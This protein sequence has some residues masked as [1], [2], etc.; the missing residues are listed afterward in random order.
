MRNTMKINNTIPWDVAPVAKTRIVLCTGLWLRMVVC[1]S[2]SWKP[3]PYVA[4]A[5]AMICD[6]RLTRSSAVWLCTSL[7]KNKENQD[8]H[9]QDNAA[10]LC[11]R[12]S[13]LRYHQATSSMTQE[14]ARPTLPRVI[15]RLTYSISFTR[16]YPKLKP[17][18]AYAM[19]C[20]LSETRKT[21]TD[22]S[23][24]T[25]QSY[26]T[27]AAR[28][29]TTRQPRAPPMTQEVARPALPRVITRLTYSISFAR[30]YPK[31]KPSQAYA[32]PC[33]LSETRKTKTNT[34]RTTRQSHATGAARSA[35]TRQ[36]RAW[37]KKSP[38]PPFPESSRGWHTAS[39]LQGD[40]RS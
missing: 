39:A 3:N 36:P 37:R 28:S 8:K 7:D 35:T 20:A 33:A 1:T 26:A 2:T 12:S 19:P 13:T 6:G 21:K 31:L 14:V 23:R 17:S 16:R 29:A 11:Y 38:G 9:V 40:I 10:V 32:M 24:T 25:R 30:R 4:K 22:T 27:G 18:Q 5:L 15:T 34:S